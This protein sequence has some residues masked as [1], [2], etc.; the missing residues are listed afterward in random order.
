MLATQQ[1]LSLVE[2]TIKPKI[3]WNLRYSQRES[4]VWKL[5]D[6]TGAQSSG[7]VIRLPPLSSNL[8]F[9]DSILEHVRKAW[10]RITNSVEGFMQF[11]DRHD[12]GYDDNSD[13]H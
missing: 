12:D 13:D 3:L 10:Q 7:A 6:E 9:D 11:D 5:L 8:A 2:E 4:T 1:L